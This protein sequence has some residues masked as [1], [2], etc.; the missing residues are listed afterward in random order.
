MLINSLTLY[1]NQLNGEV[2]Q[3]AYKLAKEL[4]VT[5]EELEEGINE[6]KAKY[7]TVTYHK[8]VPD[9]EGGKVSVVY[10]APLLK[11]LGLEE[12]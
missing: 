10:L 4:G 11:Y 7:P 8:D 6:L 1:L 12:K 9:F 3:M 2:N 5:V